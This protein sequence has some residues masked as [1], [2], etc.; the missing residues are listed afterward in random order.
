LLELANVQ[1]I[2][3]NASEVMHFRNR[4]AP[5]ARMLR[6]NRV[7]S[8]LGEISHEE[9]GSWREQLKAKKNYKYPDEKEI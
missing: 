9:I 8:G 2:A 6:T 3:S 4:T 7:T 1:R 5:W